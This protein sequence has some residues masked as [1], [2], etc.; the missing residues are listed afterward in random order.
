MLVVPRLRDSITDEQSLLSTAY[1]S[2]TFFPS[3]LLLL[4]SSPLYYYMKFLLLHLI[5]KEK[6][7][8]NLASATSTYF[9]APFCENF[10]QKLPILTISN[11]SL[12]TFCLIPLQSGFHSNHLTKMAFAKVSSDHH[13]TNSSG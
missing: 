3:C 6:K 12:P 9:S 7:S 5:I 8:L 11:S 10:S 2:S 4:E 13:I 1:L